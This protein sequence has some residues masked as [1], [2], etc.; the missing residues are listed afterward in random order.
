[1]QGIIRRSLRKSTAIDW[2]FVL[3]A[4]DTICRWV[5][6]IHPV[7]DCMG[8]SVEK[9]ARLLQEAQ[10]AGKQITAEV[11]ALLP[12][13]NTANLL[14]VVLEIDLL[15]PALATTQAHMDSTIQAVIEQLSSLMHQYIP[16]GQAGMFLASL[17]QMMCSYQQEME[18]MA[19]HQVVLLGQVIPNL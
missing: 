13:G 18:S 15:T 17:L 9:Q 6:A 5:Q 14:L 8:E 19:I 7:M 12:E 1:M 2:T 10:K 16:Q 3:G 11:L 4:T